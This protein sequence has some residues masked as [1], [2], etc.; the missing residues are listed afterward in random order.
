[1]LQEA[2]KMQAVGGSLVYST[3]TWSPEENEG[4][5]SWLLEEY[6]YLELVDVPKINGM[7]VGIDMPEVARM[8][9]HH[10]K[11]EGQFVARLQDTRPKETVT[12]KQ[13]K[14]N[15]TKQQQTYWQDFAAQH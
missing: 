4:V 15:L 13:A 5:V 10:F 12:C 7:V 14:S 3:C 1:I 6:P 11:G 2:L 8:Y 9:P